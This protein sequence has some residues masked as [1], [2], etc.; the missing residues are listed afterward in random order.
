M[1]LSLGYDVHW[2]E[3]RDRF[4]FCFQKPDGHWFTAFLS[5]PDYEVLLKQQAVAQAHRTRSFRPF[6]LEIVADP[7][8]SPPVESSLDGTSHK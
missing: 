2:D 4:V 5:A 6:R 7:E 8:A 3:R 1:R